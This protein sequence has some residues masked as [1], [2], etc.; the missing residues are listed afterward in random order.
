[1][2]NYS[3]LGGFALAAKLS[4]DERKQKE[5]LGLLEKLENEK[6]SFDPSLGEFN[7][8]DR[9]RQLGLTGKYSEVPEVQNYLSEPFSSSQTKQKIDM[10]NIELGNAKRGQ[11]NYDK[12]GKAI[13]DFVSQQ[14]L[15]DAL[16][17][18]N[19]SMKNAAIETLTPFADDTRVK[20]VFDLAGAK[21]S[22]GLGGAWDTRRG[23]YLAVTGKD[24]P[25]DLQDYGMIYGY[26]S[27]YPLTD[28]AIGKTGKKTAV[29]TAA[30]EYTKRNIQKDSPVLTEGSTG[31]LGDAAL[32]IKYL[33][34]L[35]TA[36]RKNDVGYFDVTK[37]GQFTNP[38]IQNA[39][40]QLKEIVGRNRSG[41]AISNTEWDA[42]GKE[43][44]NKN[45]LLTPEGRKTAAE[46]IDDYL[47]RFYGSG[48]TLTGDENW[49]TNYQKRIRAA[50]DSSEKKPQAKAD[51]PKEQ[52][53]TSAGKYLDEIRARRAARGQN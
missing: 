43:I 22:A 36:L 8:M 18:K 49:L 13:E 6:S 15:A 41:A 39:F 16:G 21:N 50:R 11:A 14:K 30:G 17:D 9:A 47:D 52:Q 12:A 1:M 4:E 26:G 45:L 25:E 28:D 53:P 29:T 46:S 34:S 38:E 31:A 27:T 42:F 3:G 48:M 40:T 24:K 37:A 23:D 44:L 2:P 19:F 5:A 33:N 7:M 32:G 10:G 35:K 20:E 51:Q